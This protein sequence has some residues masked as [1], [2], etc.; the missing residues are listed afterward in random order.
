MPVNKRRSVVQLFLLSVLFIN[1]VQ[2][3]AAYPDNYEES[4]GGP[5]ISLTL[6]SRCPV[7]DGLDFP[8]GKPNAKRYYNAQKFGRNNH[9]GDDWNGV[10]GGNSDLNDPVYAIANGIVVQSKNFHGGWGRVVRILHNV[11][12][13]NKP[14][15]IESLYAHMRSSLLK[16]GALVKRGQKIGTIGNANGVYWAH[17]HLEIRTII[18][19][20]LGNGYSADSRGFTDPTTFISRHRPSKRRR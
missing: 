11:G 7:A 2:V 18:N 9:L 12:T 14:V 8:V 4:S 10:G 5:S 1:L 17:L 3:N 6:I 20:P 19:K 13:K 15:Y 16:T